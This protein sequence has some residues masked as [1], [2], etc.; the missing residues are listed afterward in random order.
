MGATLVGSGSCWKNRRGQEKDVAGEK[1]RNSKKSFSSC[2][3]AK[4]LKGDLPKSRPD[5]GLLNRKK[6]AR[7]FGAKNAF[8]FGLFVLNHLQHPIHG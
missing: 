7:L 1:R 5:L 2:T 8:V 6:G 4:R 3:Q